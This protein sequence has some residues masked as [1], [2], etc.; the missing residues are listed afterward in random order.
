MPTQIDR[1]VVLDP[2]ARPRDLWSLSSVTFHGSLPATAEPPFQ[3]FPFSNA[4]PGR[5]VYCIGSANGRN[6]WLSP[7]APQSGASATIGPAWAAAGT[8][9]AAT[10]ARL[11][12]RVLRRGVM[13]GSPFERVF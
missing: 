7:C 9:N 12:T 6:G 4:P 11:V 2:A 8:A 10:A 5:S 3:R 13:W 1:L